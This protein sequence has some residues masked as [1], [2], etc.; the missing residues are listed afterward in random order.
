MIKDI[1]GRM[2]RS[3]H[4]LRHCARC[5]K[6]LTDPASWERG[7]GPLCAQ[8]DTA[9][10]A[11]TIV[12]RPAMVLAAFMAV[13]Q[14]KLPLETQEVFAILKEV[15]CEKMFNLTTQPGADGFAASGE[16]CRI[17][18]KCIDWLLSFRLDAVNKDILIGAVN[19][20]GF[21]GLAS[22]L[23]GKASTG[24]SKVEFKDGRLYLL[25]ASNKLGFLEMRKIPG[26]VLP[27][28]R[29]AKE[30]FTVPA[31]HAER[32]F[33]VA[34]EYWPMFDA[35]IAAVKKLCAEWVAANPERVEVKQSVY[36]N[37]QPIA[38]LRCRTED[39]IVNFGWVKG[40]TESVV[41]ELKGQIP[42]SSRTYNPETRNWFVKKELLDTL[43]KIL[44]GVYLIEVKET[45][46]K[47]PV[48][49]FKNYQPKSTNYR[50]SWYRY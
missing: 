11:K 12:Q 8:K 20:M 33:Q 47:T 41:S 9:L 48:G 38:T 28:Y 37:N 22:V 25:G 4:E 13:D 31:A 34:C 10:F 1:S 19:H 43:K 17:L 23:A 30:P 5:R 29:G 24:E 3:H 45:D 39:V 27:R 21:V 42:S 44:S 16:D 35:D 18:A 40:K 15:A 49:T 2:T 50:R 6:A 32:F 46:E 26:V 36:N 7:I 14:A